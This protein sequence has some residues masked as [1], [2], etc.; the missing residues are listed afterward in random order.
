MKNDLV[1]IEFGKDNLPM[2]AAYRDE[3]YKNHADIY[4]INYSKAE[5]QFYY[6]KSG[7]SGLRFSVEK[8]STFWADK[9]V[10]V[11]KYGN[12]NEVPA[13]DKRRLK[14]KPIKYGRPIEDW[15]IESETTWCTVCRDHLSEDDARVHRHLFQGDHYEWLGVGGTENEKHDY[16]KIKLSL[17][18]VLRATGIAIPLSKTIRAG[19]M[20]F[21]AIHLSGSIFGYDS[22]DCYLDGESY[23]DLF[24]HVE[25]SGD[26]RSDEEIQKMEYGIYW[27]IG[28]DNEKTKK[29]NKWTLKWIKEWQQSSKSNHH[30]AVQ[31]QEKDS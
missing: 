17:F 9:D 28:L 1:F 14:R 3:K 31:Q 4:D 2:V 25:Y 16:D 10:L 13:S 5:K 11:F 7:G 6:H 29:A 30:G 20:G 26:R 18:A 22:V 15:A 19:K 8:T 21:D 12:G 23:G 27:L 24:T